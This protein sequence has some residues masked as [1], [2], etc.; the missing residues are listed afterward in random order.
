MNIDKFIAETVQRYL[1][2]E[3]QNPFE[4][5]PQT[6]LKTLRD[7]YFQ[8]FLFNFDWN[9]KQD[10]FIG[11]G[12]EFQNWLKNNEIEEFLKNIDLLIQKTRQ[13][14]ILLKRKELADKALDYFEELIIPVLGDKVLVEPLSVFME[15]ALLNNHTV[16]D[17][18]NAYREAKNIIDAD[19]SINHSKL[20][21]SKIF[22][23]D[24]ISLPNFEKFVKN[25]PE[26]VGVFKDWEKLLNKYMELSS[27]E[28]NAYRD[29]TP[30]KSIKELYLFLVEFR[31]AR[32]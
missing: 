31:K 1:N 27:R 13:D 16:K 2:E 30:Y 20:T 29:S 21:P 12:D 11:K 22:V 7:E 18:E 19:G 3:I 17:L 14:L 15:F 8:Y 25:N 6:I 28:L 9:S 32:L 24:S 5:I 4:N 26:Y 23:G 10:E